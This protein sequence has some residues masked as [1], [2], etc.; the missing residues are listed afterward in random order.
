MR[1]SINAVIGALALLSG[2][3]A[4]ANVAVQSAALDRDNPNPALYEKDAHPFGHS[5]E[6]WSELNWQY[7][8]GI[9]AATNPILDLTGADCAVGQNGPVWQLATVVDP[10]GPASFTR[11]C[12]IPSSKAI[13]LP[14][15]GV[16]NDFPCPDPTFKPPPGQTLFQFLLLGAQQIVDGVND[17]ELSLDGHAFTNMLGYRITSDD[18][19]NITGDLSLQAGLDGCITGT[20]QP[21]VADGYFA[22]LKPLSPGPH[23]L[24]EFSSD[25][26]GTKVTVT[27]N[28]TITGDDDD[29]GKR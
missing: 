10:G 16:L 22:M 9:P 29:S 21:A 18:L 12:T 28:L 4:P 25:T 5:M 27:Y 13:A 3:G 2:C 14:L 24:V 7:I 17:I 23:T 26:H 1:T 8:Y 15:S 20:P 19:F 6:R 11:S